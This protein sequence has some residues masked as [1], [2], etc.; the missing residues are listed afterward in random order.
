VYVGVLQIVGGQDELLVAIAE[1]I[2][3]PWVQMTKS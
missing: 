2:M 3:N 1:T